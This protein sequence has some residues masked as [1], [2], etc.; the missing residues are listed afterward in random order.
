MKQI[1]LVL[2]VVTLVACERQTCDFYNPCPN[3]ASCRRG[4]CLGVIR[5]SLFPCPTY[6]LTGPPKRCNLRWRTD[7]WNCRQP[8]FTCA[9]KQ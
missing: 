6:Q 9:K 1:I 2:L 4:Y 7:K 8:Y 3:R 5:D